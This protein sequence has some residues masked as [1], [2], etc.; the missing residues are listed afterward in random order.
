MT[1]FLATLRSSTFMPHGMCYL[2][3]PGLIWLHAVS[4]TLIALSYAL[5]P[6]TLVYFVRKREDLPFNWIF[7]MFG[8][9]IFGCGTTHVM[10]VWTIWHSNYWVAGV[11]K[12][13]TAG[14]SVA[15]AG[16]LVWLV[17]TALALPSPEQLRAANAE[18]ARE[19]AA[20][21]R[22]EEALEQSRADLEARVHQRTAEL[23]DALLDLRAEMDR[24]QRAEH[25][26][27][28]AEKALR[29]AHAELAHVVRVTTMGEL[30][31]S[32]A[33]EV[34]QPLTAVITNANACL[35]WMAASPPNLAES[36][37][38]VSRILRDADRASEV[39][40]RIRGLLKKTQPQVVPQDLNDLIREVL[41]LVEG[42]LERNH[43]ETDLEL[44][45]HAPPVFGDRVQLQQ[46]V[47]N[48][49]MNGIEAMTHVSDRPRRLVISSTLTAS[50]QVEARVSDAG[51]GVA[52]TDL[53]R[54]FD[55]FFTTK[56]T[57]MG[58]GLS[59]SR[60]IVESHGGRLWASNN[61]GP[62]ATFHFTLPAIGTS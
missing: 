59:V 30:A 47:L 34:N 38:S 62:G 1:S 7:V 8:V 13:L 15:T 20:H 56:P 25:E 11:I 44:T 54:L 37:D 23:A 19:I 5:I 35:R 6:I 10:E 26:R 57:G 45:P 58:M 14:A 36:R 52:A 33:H 41:V 29:L 27:Q 9:F 16:L 22:T 21:T 43:V 4:D 51:T 53:T 49:V 61:A 2:W 31:A 50:G 3:Q 55:P 32:I 42:S 40:R 24:R 46:V 28:A 17:P 12:A 39:I 48:L 18:L 60:S